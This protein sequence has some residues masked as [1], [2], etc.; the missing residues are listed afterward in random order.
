MR[1]YYLCND[2]LHVSF[3]SVNESWKLL[4]A[5]KITKKQQ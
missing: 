3:N 2:T 4:L 1:P 5:R